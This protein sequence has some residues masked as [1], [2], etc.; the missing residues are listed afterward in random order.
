MTL[1]LLPPTLSLPPV[2]EPMSLSILQDDRQTLSEPTTAHFGINLTGEYGGMEEDY[3]KKSSFRKGH[4]TRHSYHFEK[5]R[6]SFRLDADYIHQQDPPQP[7]VEDTDTLF[8][9]SNPLFLQRVESA[10]VPPLPAPVPTYRRFGSYQG[11]PYAAPVAVRDQG[12]PRSRDSDEL[13]SA[14]STVLSATE[15]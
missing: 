2:D 13:E 12:G 9:A 6:V 14:S 8:D 10:H 1:A 4:K 15:V 7:D 3:P 11:V 5:P